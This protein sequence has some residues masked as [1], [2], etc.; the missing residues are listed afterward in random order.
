MDGGWNIVSSAYNAHIAQRHHIINYFIKKYGYK[1]YLEIGV[2]DGVNMDNVQAE[3]KMGVDP[4]PI[5]DRVTHPVDS[6]VF[7]ENNTKMFDIIFIDGLHLDHQVDLDIANSLKVL[8][9]NGTIILHDCNPPTKDHGSE[10]WILIDWNGTVWKSI[11]K[12]RCTN[13]D[14]TINV[15]NIDWGCGVLRKGKQ[16]VYNQVPLETCLTWEYF[17]INR[18]E[19]LNLI[20]TEEFTKLY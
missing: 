3:Q 8:N 2:A 10:K 9:E 16:E 19:I 4:K 11:V 20:T 1:S 13:P 7:F 12:Q 14:V 17:D 6:N 5:S 15:V 18:K